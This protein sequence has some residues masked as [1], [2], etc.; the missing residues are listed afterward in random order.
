MMKLLGYNLLISVNKFFKEK[1]KK[2]KTRGTLAIN[3]EWIHAL[4]VC[5]RVL[6]KCMH[7]TSEKT[8]GAHVSWLH[9]RM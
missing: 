7:F 6:L 2:K 1:K 5:L 4:Y 9:V 3:V 8:C